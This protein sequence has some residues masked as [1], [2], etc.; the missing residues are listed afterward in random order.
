MSR[1]RP[2]AQQIRRP[3]AAG[4]TPDPTRSSCAGA[5]RRPET[6]PPSIAKRGQRRPRARLRNYAAPLLEAPG[7]RSASWPR[8][9]LAVCCGSSLRIAV[10]SRSWIA[11]SL[12]VL[13]SSESRARVF[14]GLRRYLLW[15]RE[16]L[17]AS[18][19]ERADPDR[20]KCDSCLEIGEIRRP[21]PA[22][23]AKNQ[24]ICTICKPKF[25]QWNN[26]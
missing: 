17:M 1:G 19:A 24:P 13:G 7:E 21:S 23:T 2:A 16:I 9:P 18:G 22:R 4:L 3:S 8:V 14:F 12:V 15:A 11:T 20:P 6:T 5:R 10:R 26:H 25:A